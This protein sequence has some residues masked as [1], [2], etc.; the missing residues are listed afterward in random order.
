MLER[1]PHVSDADWAQ[2]DKAMDAITSRKPERVKPNCIEML[3][4]KC[5]QVQDEELR[6][7]AFAALRELVEGIEEVRG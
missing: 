2:Y 7:D 4:A 5:W 3:T 1:E 6:D